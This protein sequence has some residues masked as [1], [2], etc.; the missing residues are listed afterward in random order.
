M[1]QADIGAGFRLTIEL[2]EIDADGAVEPEQIRPDRRSRGIGDTDAA[3]PE[4]IAQGPINEQVAQPVLQTIRQGHRFAVENVGAATLRHRHEVLEQ[5][6]LQFAGIFHADHHRGQQA[7][8]NARWCKV[9]GRPDLAQVG[10]HRIAGLRAVDGEAGDHRLGEGKQVVAD[11]GHGQVG[12]DVAVGRHVVNLDASPR[13][14]DEGGVCLADALRLARGTGGVEH[15]RDI[16]EMPPLDLAVKKIGMVAVMDAPQLHQGLDIVQETLGVVAHAARVV[17]ND[18]LQVR[19]LPPDLQHLVDLLLV[20][21]H[22]EANAGILH[23]E[24]H[25]LSHRILIERHRY[26]AQTLGGGHHHVKMRP[27]VTHD[28]QIVTPPKPQLGQAAGQGAH[29]FGDIS[30]GPGLPDAEILLAHG[31]RLP[32]GRCMVHQQTREGVLPIRRRI[33]CLHKLSPPPQL[34]VCD[35]S[36]CGSFCPGC[37]TANLQEGKGPCRTV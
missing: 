17:I 14:R 33:L 2:F 11:P 21:D 27:V 9:V 29:T 22:H 36:G 4:Y 24:Q 1:L 31:R 7:L 23:D 35:L 25:F 13:R 3:H 10:H 12:Q 26:A 20:F 18:V 15:D 5:E 6:L 32:T 37:L 34:F 30:P 16:I 28:G 8:E 19:N